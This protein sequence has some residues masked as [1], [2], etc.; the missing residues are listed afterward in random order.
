MIFRFFI[1]GFKSTDE[2]FSVVIAEYNV[3]QQLAPSLIKEVDNLFQKLLQGDKNESTQS[4]DTQRSDREANHRPP[5][6]DTRADTET[7]QRNDTARTFW[8]D[9]R[10]LSEWSV[11]KSEEKV[12]PDNKL[13]HLLLK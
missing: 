8:T 12:N 5:R 4:T 2:L 1:Y 9:S 10:N 13:S 7:S 3:R 6:A 11:S